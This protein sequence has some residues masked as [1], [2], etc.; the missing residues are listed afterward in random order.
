MSNT[1]EVSEAVRFMV[2]RN[3]NA[4]RETLVHP[5]GYPHC[6]GQTIGIVCDEV[7]VRWD[8]VT[9]GT[10]YVKASHLVVLGQGAPI[11]YYTE[12]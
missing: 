5:I 12:D 2:S 4:C 9:L 6:T 10:E 1:R 11:D 3:L 8:D 7:L